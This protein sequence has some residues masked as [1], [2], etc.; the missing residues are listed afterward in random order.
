MQA[1][2][3]TEQKHQVATMSEVSVITLK[4]NSSPQT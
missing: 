1:E 2:S 3:V 4:Y